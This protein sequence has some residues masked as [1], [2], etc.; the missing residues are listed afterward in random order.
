MR[1]NGAALSFEQAKV[2]ADALMDGD[3]AEV[4]EK[5]SKIEAMNA[6]VRANAA[7]KSLGASVKQGQKALHDLTEQVEGI[8]T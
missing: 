7:Y 4:A 3:A 5:I 8:D 2:S 1:S 6:G